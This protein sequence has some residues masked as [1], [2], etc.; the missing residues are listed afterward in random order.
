MATHIEGSDM[1]LDLAYVR[2]Q[3]PGLESEWA[4]FDNAGGSLPAGIVIDRVTEYMRR[5]PVQLGATYQVSA[6]AG[7]HVEASRAAI[8]RLVTADVGEPASPEEIVIG[9]STSEL[10]GRLA[11]AKGARLAAGDEIIVTNFDHE[12]NITPWRRLADQG[13]VIRTWQ[14]DPE[15]C[16]PRIED[17]EVLLNRKTRL[18]CFT[19]ASNV[20]GDALPIEHITSLAHDAGAEVC[21]DGVAYAPHRALR[22]K[23]WDVDWYAFS[24]YKVFGP[25]CAVLY[26]KRD[27]MRA[28]ANQNHAFYT[29]DDLPGKLEPGAFP[30]ELAYAAGGVYDYL[31]DLARHH[32]GDRATIRDAFDRITQHERGLTTRL[33]RWLRE[34]PAVRILGSDEVHS[35]RVL[36]TVSFIVDGLRSSQVTPHADREKVGIRYGH[37]YAPRLIDAL[38]LTEQDGVVRVSMSHYNAHT[39]VERLIEVLDG[40]LYKSAA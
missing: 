10:I 40:V 5:W 29:D 37:F 2:Q 13:L 24:L 36:P 30:Y 21:V 16:T 27:A 15:T 4:F 12:A 22:V 39:E 25:H 11:R 3:F 28:V 8:A 23:D 18:V 33:L 35:S 17:L 20:I 1:L 26:G 9:A 7:A 31:R 14:I 19:H 6:D 32:A 38:G 34:Q